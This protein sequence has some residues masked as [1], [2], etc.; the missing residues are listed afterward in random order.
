MTLEEANMGLSLFNLRVSRFVQQ[1]SIG[2]I[3]V[4]HLHNVATGYSNQINYNNMTMDEVYR[5]VMEN[6]T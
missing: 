1:S 2:D 6:A 3:W 5:F 4:Y